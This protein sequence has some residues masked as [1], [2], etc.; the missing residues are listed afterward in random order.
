MKYILAISILLSF[1]SIDHKVDKTSQSAE[2]M[3]LMEQWH[4]DAATANLDAYI[5][6][7]DSSCHYIGTD[8]NENWSRDDFAAFCKPYFDKKT[9]W[10]FKTLE[11]KV[12]LNT[13]GNTAWFDEILDTHMGTC[14]GSGALEL[15]DG[16]WKLKQYI[17]SVAIP[18]ESMDAVKRSKHAADSVYKSSHP[19]KKPISV[20]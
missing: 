8:A 11:R 3:N 13:A 19:Y 16:K 4:A 12:T 6:L 2:I 5:G 10:D 7:M 17:L 1:C 18:N 9:T 20:N 14:R 15:V